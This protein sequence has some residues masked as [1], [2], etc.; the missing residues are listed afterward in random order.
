M[1]CV[2]AVEFLLS[3]PEVD[4]SRIGVMGGSQGGGLTLVTAGLCSGKIKAC[5][6]F[7]PFPCDTRDHL[8]I[9]T[10]C[11]T[12]IKNF[13]NFYNNECTLE[14]ALNIQDLL[15]TKGFAGWI[16]CPV[17]F[18]T[19]LFDDDAPPHLGFSAYNKITAPKSFKIYPDLGHLNDKTHAV[20]M[21]FL[22]E[23]LG[24]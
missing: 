23:Q 22:K 5:S 21:Q 15:D 7:D 13:L 8:K 14:D 10:M 3:R 16:K 18:V 4:S 11:N 20:Q 19:S 2:R 1:D 12:E 9:R 6:F 24:F 17:F